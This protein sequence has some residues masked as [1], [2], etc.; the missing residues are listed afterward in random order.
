MAGAEE[1]TR[2]TSAGLRLLVAAAALSPAP[3]AAGAWI[4]P[5][6]GQDITSSAVGQRDE[7]RVY[8]EGAVFIEE[9]LN[10]NTSLG[11]TAWLETDPSQG[12]GD[13]VEATFTVKRAIYR[14]E[15]NVV[16]VQ[17]GALWVSDPGEGC[18]EGGAELRVL[19]GH[20]YSDGRGFINVEGAVRALSG[21]CEGGR[22]EFTAG[23]RPNER[24]L[25]MG[26]VFMDS[27]VDGD[28]SAKAQFS[29]VRFDRSGRGWQIGLRAR[30]DGE[31]AEPAIVIGLWGRPRD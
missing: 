26:Q 9:P 27:P 31:D 19:G 7:G 16:A 15:D 28:D 24:W 8:Y 4:A 23:Y 20:S 22:A 25:A 17:A 30:I 5:E 21:G 12:D 6:G 11:L 18:S 3:A 13:R 14:S 10:A 2:S 1:E 29:L